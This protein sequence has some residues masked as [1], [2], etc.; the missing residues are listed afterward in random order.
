M[1]TVD[2]VRA[3]MDRGELILEYQPIVS[4][5]TR[6][7]LGAE[8]LVRWHRAGVVIAPRRFVPVIENTPLSGRLTYWVIDAVAAELGAW[9]SEHEDAYVSINV[10]PEILGRGGLEYAAVRSGLRAHVDQIVL[11]ITERGVPDRLGVEA[12]NTMA[13]HGVRIAL[14]DTMLSGANLALLSR[15]HFSIIKLDREITM[16]LIEHQSVPEWLVGL[17]SLLSNSSLL[18]IA[19]GVESEYQAR[20]LSAAG[21]QMAQGYLFSTPLPAKAFIQFHKESSSVRRGGTDAHG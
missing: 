3:G 7:S 8:A 2:D 13:E 21:V 15:C 11:E 18:V 9:L 5:D 19:E 4:L 14:D 17:E 1:I 16:Q 12:I 6:Y 10:P 20:M